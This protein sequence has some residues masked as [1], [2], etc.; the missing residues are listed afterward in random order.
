MSFEQAIGATTPAF[1]ALLGFLLFRQREAGRTYLTLIPIVLGIVIASNAEP[2][3]PPA[4]PPDS[5]PACSP[6]CLPA[7]LRC[8]GA[9]AAGDRQA[10][11]AGWRP[12]RRMQGHACLTPLPAHQHTLVSLTLPLIRRTAVQPGRFPGGRGGGE[13]ARAQ[14]PAAG[15]PAE[16]PRGADGLNVAPGLHGGLGRR[17]CQCRFDLTAR[18]PPLL[19]LLP[20][21]AWHCTGHCHPLQAPIAAALLVPLALVLEPGLAQQ[22]VQLGPGE[23]RAAA[24]AQAC[25]LAAPGR[26]GMR[27]L[28]L[29]G[30]IWRRRRLQTRPVAPAPHARPTPRRLLAPAGGEQRAGLGHQPHQLLGHTPHQRADA[31]GGAE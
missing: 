1:T 26:G 16:R 8:A 3:R 31:A 21:S 30:W 6:P 13:H 7:C 29:L 23:P 18:P 24:A 28:D 22:A 4:R 17:C 10:G 12:R 5:R 9:G 11:A 14:E 27:R 15:P 25:T 2:V 19:L 20:L